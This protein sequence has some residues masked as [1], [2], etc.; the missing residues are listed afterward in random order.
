MFIFRLDARKTASSYLNYLALKI[1]REGGIFKNKNFDLSAATRSAVTSAARGD[2]INLR[3]VK[4]NTSRTSG[5]VFFFFRARGN[6]YAN[7]R[8]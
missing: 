3:R 4:R 7:K 8:L 2:Q 5:C 1:K 6:L